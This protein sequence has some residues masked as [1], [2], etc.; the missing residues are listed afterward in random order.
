MSGISARFDRDLSL[1]EALSGV[2]SGYLRQAV[3]DIIPG[4]WKI[5]DA[6]NAF[7]LGHED[8]AFGEAETTAIPLRLDIITVGRLF[9]THA[10]R[11]QL[12]LAG[13]WLQMLLTACARYRMAADI[14]TEAMHADFEAL[15]R[16]HDELQQSEK[17]FRDL[18]QQLDQRVKLQVAVIEQ[19][20]R[21]LY[22]AE[23]FA[24]VGSLA[25]GM[26]HEINNPIGFIRSNLSTAIRYLSR[27]EQV[28]GGGGGSIPDH[29]RT[30]VEAML[31]DFHV[32][33]NESIGGAD[34]IAEIVSNLRAFAHIDSPSQG[35][36]DMNDALRSA[37]NM[38]LDNLSPDTMIDAELSSLPLVR[39]N[40]AHLS[41]ALFSILQNARQALGEKG[42]SIV[43]RSRVAVDEIHIEIKDSGCGIKKENLARIFDPFFTTRD[44][45]KG[46]GLGLTVSRDVVEA[47]G[48]RIDVRSMEGR[49]SIFTIHLPIA[50]RARLD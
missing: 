41:Q 16:K 22:E 15:Q 2:P 28:M 24:A 7:F 20:Q 35:E 17:R 13:T 46:S 38:A 4:A 43:I 39:G 1:A 5:V 12:E 25:A 30:D 40:G 14:H 6:D 23:K 21:R 11:Q 29:D 27:L 37:M 44:V 49:G 8:A 32:L 18:N 3:A 19:S 10:Q 50:S 9:A 34:R 36:V 42:G 47:H 48:G 31:D 45:G 33:L 26:A